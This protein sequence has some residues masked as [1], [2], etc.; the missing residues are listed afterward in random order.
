MRLTPLITLLSLSTLSAQ[1][2]LKSAPPAGHWNIGVIRQAPD[3]TG[4]YAKTGESSW[5]T[6]RDLGLGKDKTGVGVLLDYEG[7]RFLLHLATYDQSY[8]G[9]KILTQ[10]VTINNQP[11]LATARLQSQVK[12][13]DYEL[14]WTIKLWRWDAAYIGLNL[15]F[16]AWK[17]EVSA[18]GTSTSGPIVTETANDSVTVPIPQIGLSAGGHFGS[19]VDIR[20]YYN[21]L[22]KS[23]AS[24]HR[25]GVDLR[26]FPVKWL[27][28]RANLENESADIPKGSIGTDTAIHITK[29]GV[30]FGVIARF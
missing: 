22:S 30:G 27:G 10:T 5:D 20:G 16:N 7:P 18:L 1:G 4:N 15:G 29:N 9:D 11:F 26:F 19:G 2:T 24:Y 3:F 13:R 28:L 17:L 14:D 21:L 25:A 8:V 12:V 6:D 23:G